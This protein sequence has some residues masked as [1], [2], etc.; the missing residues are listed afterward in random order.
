MPIYDYLCHI[1]EKEYEVYKSIKEY[2]R[3]D[4]CPQCGRIGERL[5]SCNVTFTGTK[6]EDA[7]YNVGLGKITKSK[8]H[9]DELAKQMDLIEVGT[10]QPSKIH[11]HFDK[12]REETRQRRWDEV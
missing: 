7:E 9:R 2:R 10:E 11:K 8:K 12:Q 4:P 5:L 1:C 3:D 6:I